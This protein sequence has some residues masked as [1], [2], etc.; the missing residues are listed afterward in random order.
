MSDI[1]LKFLRNEADENDGLGHAGIQL[2]K[3]EPYASTAR[4]CGQNSSDARH[5]ARDDQPVIIDF[6][7][8]EID[9]K[10]FP[11]LDDFSDSIE[12][13]LKESEK[14]NEIESF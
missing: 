8:L 3:D 9:R 4:E 2:Y 13:C 7:L 6:E 1:C 11:A 10:D 5:D 14:A 12:S